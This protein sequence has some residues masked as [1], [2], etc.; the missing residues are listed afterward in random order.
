MKAS[1]KSEDSA[2]DEETSSAGEV[3]AQTD[4]GAG[5]RAEIKEAVQEALQDITLAVEMSGTASAAK[6]AEEE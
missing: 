1:R 5:W 6:P 4:E 3:V 2:P